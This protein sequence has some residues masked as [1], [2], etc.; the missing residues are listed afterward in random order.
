MRRRAFLRCGSVLLGILAGATAWSASQPARLVTATGILHGTL[1]VPAGDGPFPVALII[2][3]SGPTDRDGND[4]PLGLK[5]DCYRLLAQYLAR[6]GIASL[7]YDKRGAGEDALLALSESSLRLQ[8][9]VSDA[10]AWGRDLRGDA[11]FSTLAVVGHSEGSLIG[12]LAART[13]PAD[14]F[15]SIAGAGRRASTLLLTQLK[16]KLPVGL[17]RIAAGIV[18]QLAGGRSVAQVPK[19]LDAL[20]RPSVQPYLISWFRYDPVREIVRLRIPVL[21]LQGQRDLQ[22]SAGDAAA[23]HRA[24]PAAT[25][26]LIPGMNHVMKDV[27][28]SLEDNMDAYAKPGLPIDATLGRAVSGFIL[29]LAPTRESHHD[30]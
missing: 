29:H 30:N 9:Y 5:T 18:E 28:P 24:Y 25:L 10:V 19:S 13:I 22:V 4:A 11:R 20:L 6:Q 14:G 1:E 21:L 7:R 2:A 3:G 26:L 17:Y 8:T 15:V 23:L 12:M 27:G 16:P